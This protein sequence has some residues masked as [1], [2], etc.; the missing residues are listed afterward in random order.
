MSTEAEEWGKQL[1][2]AG[3]KLTRQRRA[4][5]AVIAAGETHL[6]PAE[7]YDQARIACPDLGLTTVYRTLE[8]LSELGLV[9]RVHLEKGCHSFASA[10][11]GHSHHL[12]C[13]K[14]GEVIEFEGCDLSPLLERV[15]QRTGFVIE[16]HWLELFGTCPACQ[17]VSENSPQRH[18]DTK[19]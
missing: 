12:I 17:R 1:R 9:R 13:N 5:L 10:S 3:Y 18:Q 7:V 2:L 8:I 15:A 4:V 11:G 16:A 6:S 19:K 14:C